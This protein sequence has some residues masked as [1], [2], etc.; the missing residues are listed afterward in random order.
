MKIPPEIMAAMIKVA[1]DWSVVMSK[2]PE[3]ATKELQ[4]PQM[5]QFLENN[6]AWALGHLTAV[7]GNYLRDR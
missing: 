2:T 6:F 3:T 4:P 7:I 5:S 1:G